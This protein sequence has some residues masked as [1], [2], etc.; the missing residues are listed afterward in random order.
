MSKTF[1]LSAF[2]T[3]ERQESHVAEILQEAAKAQRSKVGGN[4]RNSPLRE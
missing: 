1:R 2:G 4:I 3:L